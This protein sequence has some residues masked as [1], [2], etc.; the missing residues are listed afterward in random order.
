MSF[1]RLNESIQIKAHRS[2]YDDA[3]LKARDEMHGFKT[4]N[5]CA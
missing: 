2:H 4:L 1:K 5:D 3:Y